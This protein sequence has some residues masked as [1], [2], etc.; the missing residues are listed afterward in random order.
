[1]TPCILGNTYKNFGVK[2]GFLQQRK[3]A[4]S[5]PVPEDEGSVRV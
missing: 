3:M 4:F 5:L 2:R 1:M